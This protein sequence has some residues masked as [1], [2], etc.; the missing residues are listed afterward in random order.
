MGKQINFSGRNS[1]HKVSALN[2]SEGPKV[3][4]FN[5]YHKGKIEE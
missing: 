3:P 1:P 4:C 2:R 5:G